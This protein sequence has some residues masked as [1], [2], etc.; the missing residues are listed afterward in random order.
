MRYKPKKLINGIIHYQCC[1]C[2]NWFPIDGFYTINRGPLFIT[3]NC[4]KCHCKLSVAK[5]DKARTNELN[6]LYMQRKSTERKKNIKVEDVDGEIWNIIP[7]HSSYYVSTKG[8]VKSHKW[9]KEI[10]LKQSLSEKGYLMVR[11]DKKTYKV[12]RL[13]AIAFIKNPNNYKEINHKD[14]NK[15]NNCIENLEWCDRTYNMNYGTVKERLRI[16][17]KLKRK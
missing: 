3:S 9:G 2:K 4:K 15:Q 10:L 13:V 17:Q 11:L 6:K 16:T 7:N 12:H 14:E 8:R 5:R 1:H